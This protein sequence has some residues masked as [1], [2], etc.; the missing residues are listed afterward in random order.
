MARSD[1]HGLDMSRTF[2]PGQLL[3]PS[4]GTPRY[5]QIADAIEA[6]IDR[7]EF[8][9]GDR[10]PTVR[11]LASKLEVSGASVA[12]AYGLLARRG[13]VHAQVGRGTFV[14][15]PSAPAIPSE[16]VASRDTGPLRDAP[17]R[18]AESSRS[19]LMA[20]WRRRAL[21]IGDRL[22]ALNPDALAC[23]ASWPDPGLLPLEV[24]K[25]ALADVVARTEPSDLQY[26]GAEPHPELTE[27]LLPRLAADGV[28]AMPDDL[29]VM[30]STRQA[31][32]LTLRVAPNVVDS[33]DL[34]VAVEEPGHYSL[35]D[36]I[37]GLGHRL[38]GVD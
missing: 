21:R 1:E 9:V 8:L 33:R 34:V 5:E 3:S 4:D 24:L 6:A 36:T 19:L 17:R 38:V 32:A 31:L 13:R 29:I 10:L 26:T 22:R 25:R 2:D 20:S 18:A 11:A 30:S 37:E 16:T 14:S 35:F 27:A 7:G 28:P 15:P 23:T 12:V